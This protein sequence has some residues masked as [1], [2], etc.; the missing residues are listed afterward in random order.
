MSIQIYTI[1]PDIIKK[2]T[3][4]ELQRLRIAAYCRV[5]KATPELLH[6]LEMQLSTKTQTGHFVKF[7]AI[8][9]QA[10]ERRGVKATAKCYVMRNGIVLITYSSSH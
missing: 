4:L 7:T 9:R 6:S 5:S 8:L 1:Y 2:E 10:H 3:P